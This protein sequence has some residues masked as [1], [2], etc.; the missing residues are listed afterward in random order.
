MKI[1][2]AKKIVKRYEQAA[3]RWAR[4]SAFTAKIRCELAR[5]QCGYGW[6]T[7]EAA[8]RK[9]FGIRACRAKRSDARA[10]EGRR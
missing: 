9:K 3:E 4:D 10:C 5:L 6:D 2:Q 8:H 7:I 1:R